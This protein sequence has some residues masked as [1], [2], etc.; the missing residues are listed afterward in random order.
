MVE[1]SIEIE[2]APLEGETSIQTCNRVKENVPSLINLSNENQMYQITKNFFKRRSKYKK[3]EENDASIDDSSSSMS[4]TLK[5]TLNLP[6]KHRRSSLKHSESNQA[7]AE[8]EGNQER[9]RP[10]FED[11]QIFPS[12]PTS[13]I[14]YK[15]TLFSR[16]EADTQEDSSSFIIDTNCKVGIGFFVFLVL[17][18]ILYIVLTIGFKIEIA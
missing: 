10:V 1:P 3:K 5:E 4:E 16:F 7:L 12:K 11:L 6:K 13:K 14:E 9:P 8:L 2:T 18:E 17:L 15:D